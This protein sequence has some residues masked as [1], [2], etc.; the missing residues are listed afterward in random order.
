MATDDELREAVTQFISWLQGTVERI[1]LAIENDDMDVARD[2]L[3]EINGQVAA[4]KDAL[5]NDD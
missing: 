4:V 5:H 2:G 3:D 1:H